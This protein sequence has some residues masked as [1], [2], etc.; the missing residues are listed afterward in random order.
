MGEH[1][2][3]RPASCLSLSLDL[4]LPSRPGMR[5][6]D[7]LG[8]C[9]RHAPSIIDPA[10]SPISSLQQVGHAVVEDSKIA[11]VVRHCL[12]EDRDVA[13]GHQVQHSIVANRSMLRLALGMHL[14]QLWSGG[15][16]GREGLRACTQAADSGIG[17]M[18]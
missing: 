15:A 7:A 17:K 1:S 3:T 13:C 12:L 4:L 18:P 9:L 2:S 6:Q 14:R 8:L 16:S 10:L 5:Q 11:V